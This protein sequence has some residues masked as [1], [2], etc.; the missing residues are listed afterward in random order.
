MLKKFI[1]NTFWL[2]IGKFGTSLIAFLLVPLYTRYLNPAEF[3]FVDLFVVT[4]VFCVPIITCQTGDA[5]QTFLLKNEKDVKVVFTNSILI[6]ITVWLFSWLFYP[7]V[8]KVF[9]GSTFLIYFL[10][11]LQGAS[12]LLFNLNKGIDRLKNTT[13]ASVIESIFL[14][15]LM[16]YTLSFLKL[17]VKGYLL[18]LLISKMILFSIY[19]VISPLWKY[20]S[21]SSFSVKEVKIL[22]FFS[23]PLIPNM[24]GWWINN[25][26]DRYMIT[27]FLGMES[28]GIYAIGTKIP[29]I[30]SVFATVLISSWHITALQNYEKKRGVFFKSISY[31][32]SF[33]FLIVALLIILFRNMIFNIYV[34]SDN[35]IEALDVLILLILGAVLSAIS[36]FFGVVYLGEKQTKS[37]A[38][39]TAVGGGVNVGLNFLLIPVFGIIGAACSTFASFLVVAVLRYIYVVKITSIRIHYSVI[40]SVFIVLIITL[41]TLLNL[42]STFISNSIVVFVLLWLII[43]FFK[44]LSFKKILKQLK[45]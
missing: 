25:V 30:L 29:S 9:K 36:S 7:F 44:E 43:A 17:G 12:N 16:F 38:Y 15:A 41:F 14:L 33:S 35:Y 19:F 24:I 31:T 10:I 1:T 40:I 4:I 5:I 42:V 11:L 2:T 3:G 18:S 39:T 26:S 45:V 6:F 34:S 22:L 13:I 37:A 23:L 21:L 32:F 27:Y 8:V 20:F 28:N